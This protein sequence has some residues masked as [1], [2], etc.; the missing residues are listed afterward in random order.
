MTTRFFPA[1]KS[2]LKMRPLFH[3]D[4]LEWADILEALEEV[5]VCQ[6]FPLW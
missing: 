2:P 1:A 5:D 3:E 6:A 4:Q